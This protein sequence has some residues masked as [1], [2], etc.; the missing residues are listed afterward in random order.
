MRL[1]ALF[2]DFD[3]H[4][5]FDEGMLCFDD[6]TPLAIAKSHLESMKLE[7]KSVSDFQLVLLVHLYSG[8]YNGALKV[9]TL[10]AENMR[11]LFDD[12][13]ETGVGVEGGRSLLQLLPLMAR[14]ESLVT[15]RNFAD[16][17]YEVRDP[18][19]LK[20]FLSVTAQSL[21]RD[22]SKAVFEQIKRIRTGHG[23]FLEKVTIREGLKKVWDLFDTFELPR[24]NSSVFTTINSS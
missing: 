22:N 1:H 11:R 12:L 23:V 3:F 24:K 20:L 15:A 10:N 21:I 2:E 16:T 19:S 5:A 4:A 13:Q 9:E 8:V 14:S 6:Q 17:L 7:N 18:H